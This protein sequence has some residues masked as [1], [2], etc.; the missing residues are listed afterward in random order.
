MDE[1]QC[2]MQKANRER[3]NTKKGKN[4]TRQ[5]ISVLAERGEEN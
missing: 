4:N 2:K 3:T 5:I 1:T